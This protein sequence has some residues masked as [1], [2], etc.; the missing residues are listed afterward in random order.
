MCDEWNSCYL[1]TYKVDLIPNIGNT[2]VSNTFLRAAA[3]IQHRTMITH[4]VLVVLASYGTFSFANQYTIERWATFDV[5]TQTWQTFP[6]RLHFSSS[7]CQED[8]KT[9]C[10]SLGGLY[11]GHCLCECY[12]KTSTFGYFNSQWGCSDNVLVRQHSGMGIFSCGTCRQVFYW[13]PRNKYR[14]IFFLQFL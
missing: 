3:V 14:R 6:D 11:T 8:R 7:Q 4:L 1:V 13:K 10:N 5:Y 9:L 2:I 12:D